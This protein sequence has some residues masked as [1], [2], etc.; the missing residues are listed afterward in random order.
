LLEEVQALG[1]YEVRGTLGRGAMGIVYEGWDPLIARRVAIKAVR[2]PEHPEPETEEE[3]ARFRREAQA[4]GRLT[5]PN[6]VAVYDYGETSELAYIVMEF[7][8]GTTLKHLLDRQER[9]TVADT[10]RIMQDVL[11]GLQY[12]HTR[13]V[14]HRDIK[15]A[16]VILT[17]VGQAKI[18]DFGIAR[19][20]SSSMTQ[21]GTVLGT[22]AYMSPEQFM[23]QVVDQRTDIYSSGVLLYQLLTGERP[24][25]GSMTAI[26]HKVLNTD[27]PPPSQLTVTSPVALDAVVRRAMAK[28]PEDRYPSAAAFAEAITAAL[29]A[30]PTSTPI[31]PEAEATLV[32][33]RPS[34]A[35]GASSVSPPPSA[36]K[37]S[38]M[39]LLIA[40]TVAVIAVLAAGGGWFVLRPVPATH[41]AAVQ[42][43][44]GSAPPSS[45]A[46]PRPSAAASGVPARSQQA[47]GPSQ[48]GQAATPP[49]ATATP[50]PAAA[51][52]TSPRPATPPAIA[53]AAPAAEAPS[54]TSVGSPPPATPPA[55][56]EATASLPPPTPADRP[57][58]IAPK[59]ERM[60]S[61][62]VP[63]PPTAASAAASPPTGGTATSQPIPSQPASRTPVASAPEQVAAIGLGSLRRE[64]ERV[65]ASTR[66]T[67]V[68]SVVQDS[69]TVTV[70]GIAG[71]SAAEALR[72]GVTELAGSH[73]LD[74]RVQ[75]VDPV[76]CDALAAVRPVAPLAG[77]PD[78]GLR[79]ALTGGR[80]RL[81]DGEFIQPRVVM[82]DFS[83]R[84]RV[85][86]LA[87]DGSLVHLYPT[88]A[89]PQQGFVAVP[90]RTL[91]PKETLEIGNTGAGHPQW[92]VGPPYGTDMIIAV[93]SSLPLLDPLPAH[94]EEDNGADYIRRL[95][96]AIEAAL[97]R[98]GRV[99]GTVMLVDTLPKSP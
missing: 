33:V 46:A 68:D 95:G 90:P 69:G 54:T 37:R 76:F 66:C 43:S 63:A 32:S 23:G 49:A 1:K 89:D 17:S 21:A 35:P 99:A 71:G 5:H 31:E 44:G 18:A 28:R 70:T 93:A 85:D 57:V 19:I 40:A 60:P 47:E 39:P 80:T 65:L 42:P 73:P 22:P 64:I 3:I 38:G 50:A 87:H 77:A 59:T 67:L 74:W 78:E 97:S 45:A 51:T 10:A 41:L 14:V 2:L 52:A 79:L 55:T 20:E 7:V 62:P 24:F 53:A 58:A 26:M 4:A 15:P 9:F 96:R 30:R 82:P 61:P 36:T 92:E 86:Y 25:E 12:S 83:G 48:T 16:N 88:V 13:G 81:R 72:H 94:N 56:P 75:Q 29:A 8:D 91:H 6:I 11:S 27:P 84:L 34:S 98:G